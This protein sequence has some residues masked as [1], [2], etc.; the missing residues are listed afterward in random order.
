[1]NSGQLVSADSIDVVEM[2]EMHSYIGSKKNTRG[3]GLPSIETKNDLSVVKSAQE[4]AQ[5]EKSSG[6]I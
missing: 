2:D 4:A 1:M 5:Q 6:K 3:Y